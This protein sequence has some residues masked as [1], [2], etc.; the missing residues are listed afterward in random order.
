MALVSVRTTSFPRLVRAAWAR[1]IAR[2]TRRL[3]ETSPFKVLPAAVSSDPDRLARFEREARLLAALNHPNIAAIYGVENSSDV[4]AL[5][6][7]LVDGPTLADRITQGRN[8]RRDNRQT[9]A[10]TSGP[11]A[12]CCSKCS[13]GG[14]RSRADVTETLAFVLTKDPDWSALPPGL[15]P[16]IRTLLMHC[17]ERERRKRIGDVAAVRFVLDQAASLSIVAP[18][19][20]SV[21]TRGR[22]TRTV[23]TIAASI[24]AIAIVATAGCRR[25][26]A[27][28]LVWA[29]LLC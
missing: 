4:R 5:V 24:V 6:L 22:A 2:T 19:K 17:L 9:S 21:S 16:A 15:P 10:A 12:A 3:V 28:R 1:S 29:G 27:P 8:R 14:G 25:P 26:S 11:S 7:E 20:A 18:P 23:W 13:P